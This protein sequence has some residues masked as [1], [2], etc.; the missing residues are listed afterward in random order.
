VLV[1]LLPAW[2]APA[3][4]AVTDEEPAPVLVGEVA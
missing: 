2:L 3:P 1:A 4:E